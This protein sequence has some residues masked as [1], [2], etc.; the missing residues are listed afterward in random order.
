MIDVKTEAVPTFVALHRELLEYREMLCEFSDNKWTE[1][2]IRVVISGNRDYDAIEREPIR[3]A[4]IDGRAGDL[5]SDIPST[6]MPWISDSWQ[7][8]FSWNGVGEFPAAQR[9]KLHSLVKQAHSQ[10]KQVRFWA[11]PEHESLWKELWMPR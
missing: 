11:T 10:G 6:L 7:S 1:R 3:L 5:T 8:Q 2:P 9:E 4:G